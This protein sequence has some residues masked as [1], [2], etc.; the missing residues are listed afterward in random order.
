MTRSWAERHAPQE[1]RA[2]IPHRVPADDLVVIATSAGG[3]S[4]LP[5]VLSPLPAEFPAAVAVV[6]HRSAALP[7]LLPELLARRTPLTVKIAQEG[8]LLHGGTIYI[9]PPDLHMVLHADRTVH[10]VDGHKIRHVR[11]SANPLFESAAAVFRGH[12]IAIV[13]TGTGRDATDGVQAVKASGGIVIVQ[14][15]TGAEHASMPQS[16]I[17]SGSVDSVLPLEEIGPTLVRLLGRP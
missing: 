1:K 14:E 11:S 12:L 9:A 16:A 8:E 4:A 13:L 3:V 17:D 5:R 10:L 2:E 7:L 15:P 6:Q